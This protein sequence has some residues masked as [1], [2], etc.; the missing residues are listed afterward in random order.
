MQ[1]L[2]F[3]GVAAAAL[4]HTHGVSTSQH[5]FSYGFRGWRQRLCTHIMQRLFSHKSTRLGPVFL[6]EAPGPHSKQQGNTPPTTFR[7]HHACVP[8]ADAVCIRVRYPR[9]CLSALPPLAA[10]LQPDPLACCL[11][12]GTPTSCPCPLLPMLH[13]FSSSALSWAWDLADI[14][15]QLQMT[16]D[17]AEHWEQQLPGRVH[18]GVALVGRRPT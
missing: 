2:G 15:S 13:G 10:E 14:A 3:Q 11:F 16:W 5:L 12:C 1:G 9:R 6:P 7:L 4:M 17:I 18:T 8:A